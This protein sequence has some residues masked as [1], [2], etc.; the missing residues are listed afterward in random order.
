ML[1]VHTVLAPNPHLL[2]AQRDLLEVA[3]QLIQLDHRLYEIGEQLPLPSVYIGMEEGILPYTGVG[4]AYV[5]L[6]RVKGQ[7]LKPA[8]K[9]LLDVTQ[10]TNEDLLQHVE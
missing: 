5:T 9:A 4:L 10:K 3:M 2:A 8:I 1:T 7:H 6:Q